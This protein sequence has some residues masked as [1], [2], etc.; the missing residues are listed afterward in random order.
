MVFIF[1]F[2]SAAQ[3]H[4]CLAKVHSVDVAA[5]GSIQVNLAGMGD[6][7]ALCSLNS[8]HG[9][10]TAEA[11]KAAFSLLLAAQMSGKN[12][13]IYFRNDSN[14]SCAKG[15]WIDYAA[16]GVYYIRVEN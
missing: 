6:G 2:T 15:S 8:V 4:N 7:N 12:V 3:A 11:C 13:R 1:V 14:T 16:I 9:E 5:S 10:F